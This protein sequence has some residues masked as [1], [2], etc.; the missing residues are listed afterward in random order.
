MN[1][2]GWIGLIAGLVIGILLLLILFWSLRTPSLLGESSAAAAVPPDVTIFLSEQSL[3]RMA[4]DRLDRPV[5]IDLEENGLMRVNTRTEIQGAEPVVRLAMTIEL[6]GSEVISQL[7]WVEL[8]FL[9]IPSDWLPAETQQA[10]ALI[11]QTIKQQT[12]PDFTITNL[13]T[14]AEGIDVQLKWVGR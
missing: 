7:R 8:G 13:S 10:T 11:G 6:Q 12:P 1:R 3:S 14:T 9:T 2:A 5:V 4:S